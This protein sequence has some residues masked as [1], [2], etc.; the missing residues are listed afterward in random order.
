MI[1]LSCRCNVYVH[2]IEVHVKLMTFE[3]NTHYCNCYPPVSIINGTMVLILHIAIHSDL[4]TIE[5]TI[6]M[7]K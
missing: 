3:T 1:N 5:N 6:L 4:C 7:L 2:E